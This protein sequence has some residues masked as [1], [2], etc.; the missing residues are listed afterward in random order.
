M[1]CAVVPSMATFDTTFVSTYLLGGGVE[2][3][4]WKGFGV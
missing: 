1:T 3:E 2:E 4:F